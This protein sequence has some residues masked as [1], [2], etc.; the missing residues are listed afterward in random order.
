MC[1]YSRISKLAK[2][3]TYKNLPSLNLNKACFSS[4]VGLK[5]PSI[6]SKY[7]YTNSLCPAKHYHNS[8]VHKWHQISP[9]LKFV[10][11]SFKFLALVLTVVVGSG[12]VTS[13]VNFYIYSGK[14]PYT[15][16]RH[17]VLTPPSWD[18]GLG[19][20]F[21]KAKQL[22]MLSEEHPDSVQVKMIG[23]KIVEAL[24]S[25]LEAMKNQNVRV[26]HL[27]GFDWKFV[28]ADDFAINNALSV[29][30]GKIFIY[31]G[32]ESEAD[33]IGLLL[34]ASAG[35]DPQVAPKM[36]ERLQNLSPAESDFYHSHPS[37]KK[38]AQRLARGEVMKEASS[39]YSRVIKTRKMNDL[40][41]R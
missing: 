29:P 33:D 38:R 17:I 5:S 27:V 22:S 11:R 37:S 24:E 2:N 28:V 26:D 40:E 7:G 8:G 30:G 39:R 21:F 18:K 14:I 35:Y 6:S 9:E 31:A 13:I 20:N 32:Q 23:E 1:W 4:L 10:T 25:D 34:M 16:R 3:F 15:N 12:V 41:D 36:F 19:D